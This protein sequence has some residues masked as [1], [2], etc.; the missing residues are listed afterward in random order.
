[1]HFTLQHAVGTRERWRTAAAL[2]RASAVVIADEV[3]AIE[4]VT[5]VAVNPR[6][7]SVVLTVSSW[8]AKARTAAYFASLEA[9]P[10]IL[11]TA[12]GRELLADAERR[13]SERPAAIPEPAKAAVRAPEALD[14]EDPM[15][16][17]AEHAA[18][19]IGRG[20]T[21]MPI[22][23][24]VAEL[25]ETAKKTF[26]QGKR[27]VAAQTLG[28]GARLTLSVGR[29]GP[30]NAL[31]E[32][33]A[34]ELD[35]SS[36][37]R[38]VF[39]RPILPMAVNIGNA[40]LGAIPIIVHGV[41]SLLKGELNVAVLDASALGVSLL[42]RDFKTV[43]L[44]VLLLGLGDMLEK[45]TRKKSLASLADQL[46]LKVDRVWVRRAGELTQIPMSQVTAEDA[47]VVRA[48]S[49]IP[50]DGVVLAGD[51]AVNQA[52]M[53]GEPLPVH[54]TAG[55][56]VFA[57]TVVE[58]GE[59]DIRPT[60]LGDKS[61]LSQIVQFIETSESAKAGIQGRAEKMADAIVP[62]NFLLAGLVFLFTRDLTRTASV[63]MVDYSCALRLATPL[64]ILT[65][66]RAGTNCGVVVKG[67]RYL[68]ALSEVDAVV[69]DKTGTLTCASPVLS[70][71]VPVSDAFSRNELLTLAAC[72]EE[73]FPHPVSRAVVRKAAE[74]GLFHD[75]ERHDTEVRYIVAHGICSAVHGRKVVLGSRHFVGDDEGVDL[76]P[77]LDA[78]ERLAAEG[79]SILYLAVGGE[80]AG[81]LG[82]EDPVREEAAAAV[83]A[84]RARGIKKI[85]ML[86]GDDERTAANVAARLGLDGY[87]A[88]VLPQDKAQ[89]VLALKAEGWKVLMAGDGINDSPALSAAHVGAT[90]RD[91]TDIAQEVADVVLTQ[92]N[93]LDLANAIDL[94]RSAMRR[95][96]ENFRISVT[97]NSI[98]LAGGLTGRLMPAAGALL[99][100]ATTI[101]VCL[102]AMKPSFD[103]PGASPQS[104]HTLEEKVED[105]TESL[106]G[107]LEEIQEKSAEEAAEE[108]GA[109][110]GTARAPRRTLTP[111]APIELPAKAGASA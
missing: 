32:A 92:N 33:K 64:A 42:R 62:Y 5:G 96:R 63:L 95:I 58:D 105:L 106:R 17:I 91:G 3:S 50:V 103:L 23:A 60:A 56:S 108:A 71:V 85:I 90:L 61:R 26:D 4:G 29:A 86:T 48:G 45:Y 11:R 38:Y 99:H 40:V 89:H 76:A 30:V 81:I 35:L 36:L 46:A 70:D 68:E 59:I 44:L 20:F 65:A 97:L 101:G 51:A 84:L 28:P 31:D 79:K 57:G 98:F 69:F 67:G 27:L 52:T 19:A 78:V 21:R 94:G 107:T 66:M 16:P 37:A 2:T 39:L 73:H 87:F 80:L 111:A 7:G 14:F 100:N 24:A 9:H 75:E 83:Q 93:L 72:L 25:W 13:A 102:N 47:V 88:Q 22:L 43:G 53:T 54:R 41:K 82:I 104:R 12:R 109:A 1:M 6:T 77:G 74:E 110:G 49:V 10:P 18:K 8:E 34:A 15:Q 55:G